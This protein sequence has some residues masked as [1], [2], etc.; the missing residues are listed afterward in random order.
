MAVSGPPHG[1][2]AA[3]IAVGSRVLVGGKHK[4]T[5]RYIGPLEDQPDEWAGVEWDD[6]SRGKHDG[7]HA[8][9]RYFTCAY[10]P[11]AGSF[12]R[13]S[14]LLAAADLGCSILEATTQ[15]YRDEHQLQPGG[16]RGA[17]S[18]AA[19]GLYLPTAGNRRVAVELVGADKVA[20]RLSHLEVLQ[21]AVLV[22]C[23][24]S[25]VVRLCLPAYLP[26]CFPAHGCRRAQPG[27]WPGCCVLVAVGD[28]AAG[29]VRVHLC[30]ALSPRGH[31]RRCCC[32]CCRHH[33]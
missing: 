10:H 2:Q 16:S 22:D 9:H 5:V 25:H 7:T 8:G 28:A 17:G 13:L 3:R 18:E 6:P 11:D 24:V 32:C 26:A 19:A 27:W 23:N 14:K 15:R 31:R 1:D 12:V 30:W 4:A 29:S 33:R 20:Q 21:E